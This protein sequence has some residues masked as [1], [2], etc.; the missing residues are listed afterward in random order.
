MRKVMSGLACPKRL[1]MVTIST[2]SSMSCE[3]WVCRSAWNVTSGISILSESRPRLLR[4]H[5]ARVDR[6]RLPQIGA[7][8]REASRLR[9]AFAA[10]ARLCA[11]PAIPQPERPEALYRGGRPWT[12][13]RLEADAMCFGL[14]QRLANLS[15]LSIEIDVVPEKRQWRVFV[16]GP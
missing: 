12:S 7:H 15:N 11:V 3:A 13:A 9:A 4:S 2:P 16:A 5:S 14:L 1:L 10:P 6:P 8:R